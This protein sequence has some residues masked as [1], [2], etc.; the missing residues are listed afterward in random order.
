MS[1]SKPAYLTVAGR[2]LCQCEGH[3]GGLMDAFGFK[4]GHP[5]LADAHRTKRM[6][7]KLRHSVRVVP[8]YCPEGPKQ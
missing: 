6:L 5:S 1:T 4:C 3:I 2:P 7:Q 8:G